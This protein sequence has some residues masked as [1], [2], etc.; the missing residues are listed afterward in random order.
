VFP[1]AEAAG[2]LLQALNRLRGVRQIL[3]ATY[4]PSG[5]LALSNDGKLLI[6][7]VCR[8][9]IDSWTCQQAE[10]SVLRTDTG[11]PVAKLVLPAQAR[12]AAF[13]GDG[14]RLAISMSHDDA[15][16]RTGDS[17]ENSGR[18]TAP[19][20]VSIFN[21][22]AGLAQNSHSI[23]LGPAQLE[24]TGKGKPV[25]HISFVGKEFFLGQSDQLFIWRLA[26]GNLAQNVALRADA[27]S[28]DASTALVLDPGTPDTSGSVE[29]WDI[30]KEAKRVAVIRVPPAMSQQAAFSGDSE[31]I[32][33]LTCRIMASGRHCQGELRLIDRKL[34]RV[35]EK[36]IEREDE[37][38]PILVIASPQH[39]RWFV[40]GG[41]GA[42]TQTEACLHGRLNFWKAEK[43][44]IEEYAQPVKTFGGQVQGLTI[45]GDAKTLASMSSRGTIGLWRADAATLEATQLLPSLL[46]TQRTSQ[47]LLGQLSGATTPSTTARES[48]QK[49]EPKRSSI[50][51]GG[52]GSLN[53]I[54]VAAAQR[55]SQPKQICSV[56]AALSEI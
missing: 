18:S 39:G 43:Y 10:L 24:V 50:T 37:L 33:L 36:S 41:C 44:G 54:L 5:P 35:L 38:D 11:T 19:F 46:Q 14:R 53:P 47:S 13:D 49:A 26:D 42:S 31:S 27:I 12:S 23:A 8:E 20:T 1:S 51:C 3:P 48:V 4:D 21:L 6:A 15:V 56:G 55:L 25:Q 2:T 9:P 32:V 40:S 29:L 45:S 22:P 7:A 16:S 17:D 34:A 30:R 52:E 28:Q